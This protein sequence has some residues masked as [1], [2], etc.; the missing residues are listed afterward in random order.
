M[1]IFISSQDGQALEFQKH[2]AGSSFQSLLCRH[3]PSCHLTWQSVFLPSEHGNNCLYQAQID[4]CFILIL[5][6]LFSLFLKNL[7]L[8]EE[9]WEL[10]YGQNLHNVHKSRGIMNVRAS[11]LHIYIKHQMGTYQFVPT[12]T[13]IIFNRN[14]WT[15]HIWFQ[16]IEDLGYI[17]VNSQR[18]HLKE[19][20]ASLLVIWQVFS[21]SAL[22]DNASIEAMTLHLWD[23]L[24]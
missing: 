3:I 14:E 8:K 5:T 7:W 15:Y 11:N 17:Q 18:E 10:N 4:V 9:R 23:G 1:V 6:L 2:P 21:L 13:S 24:G 20:C 12:L 22:E 19:G 16:F